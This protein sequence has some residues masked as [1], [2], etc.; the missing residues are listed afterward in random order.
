MTSPDPPPIVT[1]DELLARFVLFSRWVREDRSLRPESFMPPPNSEL[2]VTRHFVLSESALWQIGQATADA[3]PATLYGRADFE[4]ADARRQKLQVHSAPLR[5]NRNHA[6]IT[7]WPPDKPG[8]K[9]IA[10]ELA[11]SARFV[12]RP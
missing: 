8:Q 1:D 7:G 2:S 10:Q 4:A 12:A 9:I 6:N 3:R 5:E 11:A